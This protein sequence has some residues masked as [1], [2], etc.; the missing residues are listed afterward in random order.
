MK[1]RIYQ[2]ID[3]TSVGHRA[4]RDQRFRVFLF[5]GASLLGNL[6]YGLYN[7]VLG[8]VYGSSWFGVLCAYYLALCA[9]RFSVMPRHTQRSKEND[10]SNRM[11]FNGVMLILLA[12]VLSFIVLFSLLNSVRWSIA[13]LS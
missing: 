4:I 2:L 8:A 7:G 12:L 3:R 11:I 13:W 5:T 6:M 10:E 1:R 9:M